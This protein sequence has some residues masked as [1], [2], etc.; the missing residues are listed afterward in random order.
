PLCERRQAEGTSEVKTLVR[1]S[2]GLSGRRMRGRRGKL[3]SQSAV[4]TPSRPDG[5]RRGNSLAV[6]AGSSRER[7]RRAE[8]MI[9]T[10]WHLLWAMLQSDQ[11]GPRLWFGGSETAGRL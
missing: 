10:G 8:V 1:T 2:R 11:A 7:A 3:P 5:R 4:G 6:R 9:G